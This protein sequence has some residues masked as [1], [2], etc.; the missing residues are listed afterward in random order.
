LGSQE[1]HVLLAMAIGL[2]IGVERERRR[3]DE[4][5]SSFAGVRT[6]GLVGLLGGV[7]GRLGSIPLIAVGAGSV[8]LLAVVAYV[9]NRKD[10]DRGVTT[11]VAMMVTFTLGVLAEREPTMAAA[12]GV[13][14]T[15]VLALRSSLH[16]AVREGISAAELRDGLLLLV[17]ALVVLPLAPDAGVGPYAAIHPASL[18]RLVVVMM[19]INALGHAALRLLGARLGLPITGLAGGFV[20]SSATIASMSLRAKQSPESYQG[21]VAG[22]LASCV[23]TGIQYLVIVASI[24]TSLLATMALPFGA[25]AIVA[26]VGAAAFTLRAKQRGEV[27][28]G[29]EQRSFR[30]VGAL[31]LVAV[32]CGVSILSAALHASLGATGTVL[33]SGVAGFID[34]HSTAAS[35]AAQQLAGQVDTSTARIASLTALT[36]NTLSK[37]ALA[38]TGRHVP[39]GVWTTAGV[40]LIT[41]SAWLTLLVY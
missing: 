20:S 32:Y 30:L 22:A 18:V 29:A 1:L 34:A 12:T 8:A 40:V 24:D 37:V 41:L 21:P 14:V 36:T 4:A 5:Y 38:W 6:F 10:Q 33:V 2:L 28:E 13:I 23:A 39:F 16:R 7:L 3:S 26:G 27:A 25:S 15:V 11:E 31:V 19:G 9:V 35:I 17:F